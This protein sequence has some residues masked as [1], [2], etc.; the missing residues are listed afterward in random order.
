MPRTRAAALALTALLLAGCAGERD[1]DTGP[2]APTVPATPSPKVPAASSRP[3]DHDAHVPRAGR[4]DEGDASAV[5][6]K[7]A[8]FAYG[9]DTAYDAHPHAARLRA[10][11]YLTP[12]KAAAATSYSPASGPGVQWNT[13]ASHRAWT[14]AHAAPAEPDED[15][16]P[17]TGTLAHRVVA[18]DG[19][20][21][22]RDGWTGPGPRLHAYLTLT[23]TGPDAPWRVSDTDIVPAVSPPSRRP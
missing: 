12:E 10:A 8:E 14:E 1:G 3:L 19:T 2:T 9:Y 21:H 7:W 22:G 20:A 16:E 6:L 11:R 23:R 15:A 18:V 17:D 5:A 13:W 4:I